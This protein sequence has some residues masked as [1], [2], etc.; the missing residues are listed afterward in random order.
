MPWVFKSPHMHGPLVNF[1]QFQIL[2][3]E[4]KSIDLFWSIRKVTFNDEITFAFWAN[5][6]EKANKHIL[7]TATCLSL[8]ISF[9]GG[10]F[11]QKK[12]LGKVIKL[13]DWWNKHTV[14]GTPVRSQVGKGL[15]I[16]LLLIYICL[17]LFL[18]I[19][20]LFWLKLNAKVYT[21]SLPLHDHRM[22][23]LEG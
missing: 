4:Y 21:I 16:R 19:C 5:I 1:N 6:I 7:L 12:M 14:H 8:I 17:G 2:K 23:L 13:A 15:A 10:F 18:Q 22:G 3:P 20:K 11:L 9:A